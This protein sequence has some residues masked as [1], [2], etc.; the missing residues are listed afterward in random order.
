MRAV[1]AVAVVLLGCRSDFQLEP[2]VRGSA[3]LADAG[4]GEIVR[5][6]SPITLD[7]SAS[8][9]PDGSIA[10][11][12]W[13]LLSAPAGSM[14][15][16]ADASLP[17]TML[18]PDVAGD[19]ELELEV[20]D[21]AGNRDQS[22]VSYRVLLLPLTVE[23][24]ADLAIQ[25]RK[26]TQLTGQL[27]NAEDPDQPVL[28]WSFVS[29]PARST[30]VLE[31]PSTLAPSFVAD[32]VGTY[33]VQLVATTSAHASTDTVTVVVTA[34]QVAFQGAF[35][36]AV[37]DEEHDQLL[38]I[39]DGPPRLRFINPVTA[40]ETTIALPST[41]IA[42][43]IA[44]TRRLA[45]ATSGQVHI[46]DLTNNTLMASHDVSFAI[47]SLAFAPFGL[48]H[49]LTPQAGPIQTLDVENGT[50][51]TSAHSVSAGSVLK[52]ARNGSDLFSLDT[53]ITPADLTRHVSLAPAEFWRDSP[54][55]G[56]YA[57]GNNF[58]IDF[59]T[60]YVRAGNAFKVTVFAETD[61]VFRAHLAG[62]EPST[63]EYARALLPK[64]LTLHARSGVTPANFQLRAYDEETLA[65]LDAAP[66]PE[67]IVNGVPQ[68]STGRLI[69][70]SLGHADHVVIVASAGT[71]NAFIVTFL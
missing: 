12:Q 36:D 60:I 15:A 21:D 24:G 6:S 59:D 67:I 19:Y 16:I 27:L 41:P 17:V 43:S 50:V 35:I 5:I 23:A 46:F 49:C 44:G 29:K 37:F 20:T 54:Y 70:Y 22:R 31:N 33:V 10:T 25:W 39:S 51:T 4:I 63:L 56:E 40:A 3:P 61:M 57:L 7:G 2:A 38:A 18:T 69:G 55:A 71:S 32:A 66:L 26:R 42:L 1:V 11:Y 64:V 9:D 58:W 13:R 45:V 65:L 30:T 28:T 14:A 68:P 47:S 62:D 34:K 53:T 8:V 52:T 48:V